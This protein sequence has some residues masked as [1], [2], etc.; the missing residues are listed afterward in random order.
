[1][2]RGIARVALGL[3]GCLSLVFADTLVLKSGST[4]QGSFISGSDR[5]IRFATGDHVS[6]Y[7]ITDIDSIKFGGP[8]ANQ[9]NKDAPSASN[10]QWPA[11][12]ENAPQ[13]QRQN[14][15]DSAPSAAPSPGTVVGAGSVIPG[16]TPIVVR[17]ID[18]VDSKEA[19]SGQT[20]HASLDEP[21]T[22]DGKTVIP[23]GADVTTILASA[24]QS[25]KFQG[26]AELT[27]DIES[28]QADGHTY[29]VRTTGV[30]EASN[31]R[32]SRTAKVV[33]G[34]AALGAIIG[35][36][37]GGGKGAAIGAGA[38]AATGAG[39]QAVTSGQRV[40]IPP[41]TRLT[42]TLK[43]DLQL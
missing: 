9:V 18:G 7:S 19:R 34:T 25:G 39:V 35:A 2:L 31:G 13:S 27:L 20:F 42:F 22:V 36:I 23:R 4:V 43:N 40:Q 26:K 29:P 3:V 33:G 38:G 30:V 17:M 5:S 11:A 8:Q 6:T 32:G 12:Q 10:S 15:A 37:A 14:A 24:Q 41:E 16:G 28:I 1:M 21:I